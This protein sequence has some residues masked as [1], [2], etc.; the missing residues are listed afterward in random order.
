MERCELCDG[1]EWVPTAPS[2]L[3][4]RLAVGDI[5]HA[6]TSSGDGASLICLVMSVSETIISARTVTS[7]YH[8]EFDRRTGIGK[9]GGDSVCRINSVTPLPL[10]HHNTMLGLDRKM[11]LERD[12]ERFKLCEAEKKALI[13][14][15]K[16]YA[17]YRF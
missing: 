14:A 9:W 13:Y 15:A 11:R 10:E 2:V 5:F 12:P 17:D 1:G 6:D 8:L 7:Q 4:S 3:I 16:H